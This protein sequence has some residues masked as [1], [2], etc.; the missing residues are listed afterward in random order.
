[1]TNIEIFNLLRFARAY[2]A[3]QL[4]W[5]SPALF[6]CRICLTEAVPVAAIST[7]MDIFFNPKAVALIYTTAGSKED[8]LKQL[9]FLWVHEISHILRE[10]AERALEF[11]ADAQLWNIAADLEINDSRWQGTQAPVAFKGIFLKDFKLPEGQIAEWYY[12]QLSSNAA[13]GQRLIQQHQQG[14]GDEGSGTH[15]QPREWELGKSE[16]QQAAQELSKL[17]KQVVSAVWQKK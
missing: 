3:E 2:T 5:F 14:L 1:M 15:G 12:R 16:A 17:E 11:N 4:P 7:N 6:R 13:L 8:A 9:A 10:H